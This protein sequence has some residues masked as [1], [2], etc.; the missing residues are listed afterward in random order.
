M[1]TSQTR[2]RGRRIGS[3]IGF[4][5]IFALVAGVGFFA[6]GPPSA[7][8]ARDALAAMAPAGAGPDGYRPDDDASPTVQEIG[9]W[10]ETLRVA[11][12]TV[13]AYVLLGNAYL[14]HVRDTGDPTNYGRADAAFAEALRREP[15]NVDAL[16]GRGTLK[17]ARHDFDGALADGQHAISLAPRNARAHGVLADAL[18]ELGRYD[19][20]VKAVQSMVDLRPNAAAYTRVAYQR[21]L[22]GDL[23]G[24]LAA[25][26][27]A[28]ES[29][30]GGNL[31]NREYVRVLIGDLLLRLNEPER[32]EATYRASLE[33]APD[34]VWALAGLARVHAWRGEYEPA[35][36]LYQRAAAV[37][38]LPELVIAAGR[39][40]EAAGLELEARNTFELINAMRALFEAN[41]VNVDLDL[42]LFEA[43]H[44]SSAR[45]VDMAQ[46]AYRQQPN[47]RAA[48][49]LA[50]ALRSDGQLDEAERYAGEA[51]RLGSREPSFHFHAGVIALDRGDP[52]TA[53]QRLET[54]LAAPAALNPLDARAAHDAIARLND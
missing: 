6:F 18:T 21:E 22:R 44:G 24:A 41:G 3:G 46:R 23:E 53:R 32:A 35:L 38:P 52:E 19:D 4:A 2:R 12:D 34:F 51:L 39:V 26:E 54:A 17:L 25:M 45:A 11:P 40:Q 7:A 48:D 1:S 27:T 49:A 8:P 28:F 30:R 31:E 47:T 10:Y 43:E 5:L 29:L 42:A 14:Q 50:W 36:E 13:M 33:V 37:A 15:A 20:A 9:R 16:V